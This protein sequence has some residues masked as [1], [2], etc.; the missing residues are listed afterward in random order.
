MPQ[1]VALNSNPGIHPEQVASFTAS[2]DLSGLALSRP[3]AVS[4]DT[5]EVGT[6]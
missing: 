6:A 2:S 3:N 1:G 4:A 5:E